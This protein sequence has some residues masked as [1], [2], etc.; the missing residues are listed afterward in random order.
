[1]RAVRL[2]SRSRIRKA[3]PTVQAVAIE[4]PCRYSCREAAEVAVR[5]RLQFHRDAVNYGVHLLALGRPYPEMHALG[6]EMR[7]NARFLPAKP[8]GLACEP[9]SAFSRTGHRATIA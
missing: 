5:F 1:M 6:C 2:K 4:R 7:E 3:V 9:V 8:T